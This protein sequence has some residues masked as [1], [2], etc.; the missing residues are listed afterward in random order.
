MGL[1][2]KPASQANLPI[3]TPATMGG[4]VPGGMGAGP[5]LGLFANMNMDSTKSNNQEFSKQVPTS[6]MSN[7]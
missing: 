2:T 3:T 5:G 6:L 4:G 7:T 1:S